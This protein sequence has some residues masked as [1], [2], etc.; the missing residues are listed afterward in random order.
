MEDQIEEIVR[1]YFRLINEEKFDEFFALFDPDVEFHAP[2]NFH[3]NGLENMK[4]FY[5]QIPDNYPEHVDYPQDI[6]VSGNKAAVFID[7][8]VTTK[9][10][11][12]LSS[13]A[14]DW[15]RIENG[16]IKSLNIFLDSFHLYNTLFAESDKS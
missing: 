9:E 6:N 3:A 12:P 7:F 13:T 16:K 14:T 10:G 8:K 11:K 5:L 15:F 1:S 2:F 4:P